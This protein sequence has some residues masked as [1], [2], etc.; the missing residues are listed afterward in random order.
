MDGAA[1]ALPFPG[2][3]EIALIK[4]TARARPAAGG[5]AKT[6]SNPAVDAARNPTNNS[7]RG[8]ARDTSD[9]TIYHALSNSTANSAHNPTQ[10]ARAPKY[11][12]MISGLPQKPPPTRRGRAGTGVEH[13]TQQ[14]RGIL[15]FQ[16]HLE[17]D[18]G[19]AIGSGS[20]ERE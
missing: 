4:P 5:T 15:S 20:S 9:H 10:R 19:A 3:L 16:S 17:L 1:K 7:A 6:D 18:D 13:A 11:R 12:L 2:P 14:L 8:A